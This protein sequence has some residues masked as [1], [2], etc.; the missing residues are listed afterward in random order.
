MS[1]VFLK[2]FWWLPFG[3]V[4]G[5]NAEEL[6]RIINKR[7]RKAPQLLDVRTAQEWNH[8]HIKN[9]LNVPIGTLKSQ[10]QAL[11]FDKSQPVYAICRSAHRS[12]PAVR[13]LQMNGYT[14]VKQLEGGMTAWERRGFP[15]LNS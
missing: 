8:G 12:I 6:A 11:P 3:S 2:Y 1:D 13:L 15:T 10:M 7:G 9:T 14:D 4:P 5:L